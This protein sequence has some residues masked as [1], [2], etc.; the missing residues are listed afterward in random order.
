MRVGPER[1]PSFPS[2]RSTSP[3]NIGYHALERVPFTLNRKCAGPRSRFLCLV[4]FSTENRKSTFPEN[5]LAPK[6]VRLGHFARFAKRVR[7]AR[8]LVMQEDRKLR[9][10]G[11]TLRG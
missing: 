3:D 10:Y 8:M 11:F 9:S 6:T 2:T 7:S 4:A 1:F 5:A